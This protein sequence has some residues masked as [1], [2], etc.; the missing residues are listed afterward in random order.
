MPNFVQLLHGRWLNTPQIE[1]Q[2]KL[3]VLLYKDVVF[4]C[5]DGT[6]LVVP[7]LTV[8][9]Q[10]KSALASDT[11]IQWALMGNPEKAAVLLGA[12]RNGR[13]EVKVCQA[14]QMSR[15]WLAGLTTAATALTVAPPFLSA[16]L[17]LLSLPAAWA[18]L[19]LFKAWRAFPSERSVRKLLAKTLS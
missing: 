9:Q 11:P 7:Q 12:A 18:A 16:W 3:D 19:A 17:L 14:I 10:L 1:P 6:S 2:A 8:P 5:A 13:T 4:E 15:R